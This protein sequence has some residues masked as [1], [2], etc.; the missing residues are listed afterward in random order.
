MKT[1]NKIILGVLLIAILVWHGSHD[2]SIE[3]N[4]A[5]ERPE[6]IGIMY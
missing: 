5:T 3:M 1:L 6:T 4:K 2:P